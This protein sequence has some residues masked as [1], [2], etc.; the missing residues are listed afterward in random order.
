MKKLEIKK[1]LFLFTAV[2]ALCFTVSAQVSQV[3]GRV[4][5]SKSGEA[6]SGVTVVEVNLNDRQVNG[7]NSDNEGNYSLQVSNPA[8]KLRFSFIGYES[9]TE[10]ELL[11]DSTSTFITSQNLTN[12]KLNDLMTEKEK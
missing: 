5:D 8:H 2:G 12:T 3:K 6:L 7:V 9:K 10:T 11:K 4:T 1:W